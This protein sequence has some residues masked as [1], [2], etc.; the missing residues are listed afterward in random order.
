MADDLTLP[1][2]ARRVGES[3]ERLREWRSLRLLGRAGDDTFAPADLERARLVSLL[4]RR[5]IS[6]ETIVR[7]NDDEAILD[8]VVQV[9]FPG[10]I[11]RAYTPS[12]AA[13]RLALEID[14]FGKL[15]AIA[16]LHDD[17]EVLYDDDLAGLATTR[18]A[19]AAGL[20]EEAM[21][22]LARV[23]VDA[24]GR[25]A[26]TEARVVHF[27]VH[28]HAANPHDASTRELIAMDRR[29]SDRLRP[30]SEPMILYFHR[31]ALR[32]ALR[33]DA[34]M[35][36]QE[37]AG[38][39]G[40][41]EIPGQIRIAI[42]FVDL[43]GFTSLADAMGDRMAAAVLERFSHIVRDHAARCEGQVV[44][45]I[46]DAFMLAFP[47]AR[48]AV[49]CAL[50]IERD[51]AREPQFPAVRSGVHYGEVLYREGDYVG[52]SVNIA[53]RV[54]GEAA[55]HQ[56]LVTDV[57]Y[58]EAEGL[59]DVRFVALGTRRLRGIA[60]EIDLF[61]ALPHGAESPTA[62]RA[63]DPVCGMELGP[64]EEAARLAFEGHERVF[65]SPRCLQR[66]VAQ[67]ELYRA[68]T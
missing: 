36:I 62:V 2:L 55:R 8:R 66:F 35:Y 58:R 23:Y 60:Q 3:P 65:C 32:N 40:H 29:S 33:E 22:Q 41:T 13:A 10:G 53:A 48:S 44:K 52:T 31:R 49:A 63:L 6:L 46:G 54:A 39:R 42:A 4:L 50:A 11:G 19:L 59:H 16:G 25:V 56:V 26:D 57:T 28:Q 34:V 20:P 15:R 38:V 67:P 37:R 7:V 21:R 64:G 17:A 43:A 45:Q 30:L 5:G 9:M 61:A 27:Y 18:S 47:D 51:T 24:L 14:A 1:E 12:E 68:R